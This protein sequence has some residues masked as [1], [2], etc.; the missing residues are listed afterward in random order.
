M[1]KFLK[2]LLGSAPDRQIT[3]SF[4]EVPSWLDEREKAARET[5]H[6]EVQEPMENIRN[7]SANLQS[8]GQ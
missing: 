2:S 1:L 8:D 4:E 7:A 3:L 6:D 5:L